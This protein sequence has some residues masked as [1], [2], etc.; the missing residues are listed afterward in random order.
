MSGT[1]D[2]VEPIR[3]SL[4]ELQERDSGWVLSRILNLTVNVNKLNLLSA[5]CHIEVPWEVATKRAVINVQRTMR[6]QWSPYSVE[7]YTEQES[8]YPHYTAVLNL[9]NIEFP[10]TL[11]DISKF[12]RLNTVSI[13]VYVL[14]MD[15]SFL[16]G[17]PITRKKSISISFTYKIHDSIRYFAWIKNLSCLVS[18]QISG[19][20]N[21]KFFCDR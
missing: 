15:R 12:E 20:K 21:K 2:I 3:A 11:Q 19:K 6:G 5:G 13:N 18:S 16:C 4:E 7:K 1:S 9:A 10:I 17:L 8:S 14:K